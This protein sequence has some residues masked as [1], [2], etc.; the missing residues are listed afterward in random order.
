MYSLQIF[1]PLSRRWG[2]GRGRRGGLSAQATGPSAWNDGGSRRPGPPTLLP[3][4]ASPRRSVAS[5]HSP[6]TLRA[7]ST[8]APGSHRWKLLESRRCLASLTWELEVQQDQCASRR[9]MVSMLR[10]LLPPRDLRH[11]TGS[12]PAGGSCWSFLRSRLPAK[13]LHFLPTPGSWSQGSAV[14]S[15]TWSW[16][17]HPAGGSSSPPSDGSRRGTTLCSGLS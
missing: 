7:Q 5:H 13:P 2:G 4:E 14:A 16:G 11:C 1:L 15:S 8:W 10:G 6:Y 17:G 9:P 12:S 3:P